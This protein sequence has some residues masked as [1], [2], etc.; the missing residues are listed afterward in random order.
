MIKHTITL[1]VLALSL[2]L[3]GPALA[4]EAEKGPNGGALIDVKGHH[5]E[6]VSTPGAL[7]I[8]LTDVNEAPLDTNGARMKAIVQNAGKTTQLELVPA[9]P[10]KLTA[11]T[12][13]PVTSGA[14]VVI[15]GSLP[16]G[17]KIQGRFVVP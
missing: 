1:A 10:N 11:A 16:N 4:H 9:E 2:G 13:S 17:H 12:S 15:T 5:L 6:L 3:N 8:Y 14:K 7:T